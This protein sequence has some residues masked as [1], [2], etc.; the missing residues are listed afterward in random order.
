MKLNTDV[1][2]TFNLKGRVREINTITDSVASQTHKVCGRFSH[3]G[4]AHALKASKV[5]GQASRARGWAARRL[6]ESW[7]S[8]AEGA[9]GKRRRE[10]F[11]T[12]GAGASDDLFRTPI[13]DHLVHVELGVVAARRP[14][15]VVVVRP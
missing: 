6:R 4:H 7:G 1:K 14:G 15:P 12:K 13:D 5:R 10:R 8:D 3:L 11:R 2:V 9:P